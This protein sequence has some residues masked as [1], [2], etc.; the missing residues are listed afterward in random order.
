MPPAR[1]S[2]KPWRSDSDPDN[3]LFCRC[4]W[5]VSLHRDV[6]ASGHALPSLHIHD[7]AFYPYAN[8]SGASSSYG[9][10]CNPDAPNIVN[11]AVPP[12]TD[13]ATFMKLFATIVEKVAAFQPSILFISGA[14]LRPPPHPSPPRTAPCS[15]TQ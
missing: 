13:A 11:V 9:C 10:A 12:H 15:T 5:R 7:P 3:V 4:H 14:T 1:A 6:C 8:T 2:Y